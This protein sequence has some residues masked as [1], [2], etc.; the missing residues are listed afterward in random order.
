MRY[1][2]PPTDENEQPFAAGE[3]FETCVS[4]VRNPA[5]RAQL[6]AVRQVLETEAA[7]Y[8]A[9]AADKQLYRKQNI[10]KIDINHNIN[11]KENKNK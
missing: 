1:L 4:M 6:L 11:R 5:L 3:V 9:K 10:I 7:D 2:Q 8:D